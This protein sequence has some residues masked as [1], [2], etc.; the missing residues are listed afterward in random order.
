MLH[1]VPRHLVEPL[2]GGDDVIVAFEFP[3]Q[4]LLDIDVVGLQLLQLF[5]NA[6]VEVADGHAQLLA[7][8][9]VVERHRGVVVHRPLKVVGGDI[10]AEHPP[11]DLVVLEQRRAG[12]ADVAGIGQGIAHVERQRAVLGAVCL[13][14]DDD[15]VVALAIGLFRLH[16]LVE[17]LD[18]RKDVGLVL[19]Q[20][21]VQVMAAGGPAR[22]L[23]VVTTPQ[24]AKVL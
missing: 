20:Q 21:L 17:L 7:A 18:Q 9:V 14:G 10:L 24:P 15:D 16:L 5:G 1:E 4:P 6:F 19:G 13:V 8:G 11:R 12:K 23:V 22:L 2:V 3:L